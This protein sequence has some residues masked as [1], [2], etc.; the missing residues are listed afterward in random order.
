MIQFHL[1]DN[2]EEPVS[3]SVGDS[4]TPYYCVEA[5]ADGYVYTAVFDA[6]HLEGGTQM[7]GGSPVSTYTL[8]LQA[9]FRQIRVRAERTSGSPRDRIRIRV[10]GPSYE[11]TR[12]T[13]SQG[14]PGEVVFY[15]LA[16]GTY[17]VQRRRGGSWT[18]RRDINVT[19]G[20]Y[21]VLYRY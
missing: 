6:I 19:H 11:M 2:Q 10:T 13:G 8:E 9:D 15:D 7:V 17:Q 4:Y 18:D 1:E 21:F 5:S 12:L 16:P 20:E 3:P 14:V